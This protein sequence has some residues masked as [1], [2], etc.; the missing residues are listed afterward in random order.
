MGPSHFKSGQVSLPCV[1]YNFLQ[2]FIE[3]KCAKNVVR[4]KLNND[5]FM[6]G[7]VTISHDTKF[8]GR[9]SKTQYLISVWILRGKSVI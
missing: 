2:L 9:Q 4:R 8:L 6:G 7:Y 1:S 3:D 5:L